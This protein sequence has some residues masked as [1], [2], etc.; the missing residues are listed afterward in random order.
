MGFF[1]W[2][3]NDTEVSISNEHSSQGVREVV[4]IDNKDN[5]WEESSYDG[6]GNFGG[7]DY[8]ELLAEMNG[9]GSNRSIGIDLDFSGDTSII[10]PNLIEKENFEAGWKWVN[11]KPKHCPSQGFFY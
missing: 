4:M 8:Y 5:H 11:E 9:K 7:K 2:L 3:T 6:Y 10:F 1:S